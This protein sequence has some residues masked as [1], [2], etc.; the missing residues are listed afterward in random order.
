[1]LSG[2]A[3]ATEKSGAVPADARLTAAHFRYATNASRFVLDP[4]VPFGL[5]FR[6][7]PFNATFT[8]AVGGVE[9]PVT[10]PV[11]ARSEA[12]LFSGEKRAEVHVVPAFAVTASPETSSSPPRATPQNARGT[13]KDVRV[14]VVNHFK[15]AATGEATLE[16]P[17]GWRAT[18]ATQPVSFSRED[19]AI[20]VRFLIDVPPSPMLV[21]AA[22]K[23]GGIARSRSRR[24]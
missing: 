21:S 16:L 22:T 13:R 3:Q 12:D 8:L 7:T 18:P 11:Q 2:F 19:E 14:T 15:G 5:P 23:P 17:Q 20:T 6:P 9:F 10:V 4:D 1:M 24:W